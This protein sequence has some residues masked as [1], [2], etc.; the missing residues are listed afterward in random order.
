VFAAFHDSSNERQ[1]AELIFIDQGR[2]SIFW[3]G[4]SKIQFYKDFCQAISPCI[5]ISP[6]AEGSMTLYAYGVR[7]TVQLMP[8]LSS[9]TG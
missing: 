4:L 1:I 2:Q 5:G 3:I 9:L 7:G 8:H 6:D